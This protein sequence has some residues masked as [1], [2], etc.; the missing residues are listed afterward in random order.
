[1]NIWQR[2]LQLFLKKLILL[3]TKGTLKSTKRDTNWNFSLDLT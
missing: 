2:H 3:L 1:M